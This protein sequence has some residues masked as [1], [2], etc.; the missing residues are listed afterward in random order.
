MGVPVLELVV[1]QDRFLSRFS[2]K[3]NKQAKNPN[4]DNK[5][6]YPVY[7]GFN[8]LFKELGDLFLH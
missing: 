5:T 6:S 8:F 3:T 2:V 1:S 4:N 7:C